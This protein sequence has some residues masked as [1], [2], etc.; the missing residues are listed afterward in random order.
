MKM[1][2]NFIFTIMQN[3]DSLYRK[4][5]FSGGV[6]NSC[7][8][9]GIIQETRQ[10]LYVNLLPKAYGNFLWGLYNCSSQFGK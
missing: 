2:T 7:Q 3:R 6:K 8:N 5:F 1:A 4:V 10:E 9:V